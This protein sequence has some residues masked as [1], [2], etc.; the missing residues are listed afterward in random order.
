MARQLSWSD[1]RGGLIALVVLVVAALGIL[2]F[3]RVGALHGDTIRVYA[4]VGGARGV[5]PGSEVWLSGQ[6]I[7]KVTR[8][9]FL[10]PSTDTSRRI[11]MEMR[12]LSQYR[13]AVHSDATAQV[14]AG[15]SLVGAMVVSLTPGTAR[16]APLADGDTILAKPQAD[17][18][19]ATGQFGAV[20]RELPAIAG[21]VKLLVSE[22][23]SERGTIGAMF[24]GPGLAGI[25]ET[26]RQTS[27]VMGRMQGRGTV[28][29]IMDG[30][31]TAR[32]SRVMSRVDS[33]RALLA[34]NR[35]TLGRLRRD[36]TLMTEVGNIREELAKVQQS[37]D[38]PRGTAG[39]VM[40]DSA[41]ATALAGARQEMTLLFADMKK[42][43]TRYLSF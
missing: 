17:V 26:R 12:I 30:G 39:R 28:A 40:H 3:L 27:R 6:K 11:V 43:P 15:G 31:L 1:V 16:T 38:E 2:R 32:A 37:L 36:S 10:P 34:S 23:Q 35:T 22:L 9:E 42:H 8:I 7:G 25:R 13:P 18:D 24:N 14:G 5:T 29:R 33:V 4:L 21:N 20:T 19:G 41:F